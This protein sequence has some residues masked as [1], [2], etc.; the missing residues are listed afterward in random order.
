M[1]NFFL[2]LRISPRVFRRSANFRENSWIV[3]VHIVLLASL[4]ML[5]LFLASLL[6]RVGILTVPGLPSAVD[7]VMFLLSLLLLATLHAVAGFNVFASI[8][9]F[10]CVHP[11]LVVLL[12]LTFLLLLAVLLL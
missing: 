7:A 3:G 8:P 4:L 5:V 6:L 9:A 2:F 10:D 11:V 1:G 12:L